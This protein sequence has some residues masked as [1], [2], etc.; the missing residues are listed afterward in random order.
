MQHCW[1]S[2]QGLCLD[3]L[4]DDIVPAG[5]EARSNHSF[6]KQLLLSLLTVLLR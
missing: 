3:T 6:M 5:Q 4:L 2:K 1:H